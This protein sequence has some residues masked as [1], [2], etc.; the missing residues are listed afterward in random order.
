M[1]LA[2]QIVEAEIGSKKDLEQLLNGALPVDPLLGR[3][4]LGAKN[5]R[6]LA[7]Y[8]TNTTKLFC[9][10]KTDSDEGNNAQWALDTRETLQAWQKLYEIKPNFSE[11]ELNVLETTYFPTRRQAVSFFLKF[12]KSQE[13]VRNNLGIEKIELPPV[14]ERLEIL[15]QTLATYG[16]YPKKVAAREN[17]PLLCFA[18]GESRAKTPEEAIQA[19][20]GAAARCYL[21]VAGANAA[22]RQDG[23]WQIDFVANNLYENNIDID[24]FV[25]T[26]FINEVPGYGEQQRLKKFKDALRKHGIPAYRF[27]IQAFSSPDEPDK[28]FTEIR[29][30]WDNQVTNYSI[31]KS[32]EIGEAA[33]KES[34]YEVSTLGTYGHGWGRHLAILVKTLGVMNS[35]PAQDI[36]FESD[37]EAFAEIAAARQGTLGDEL[38]L[39]RLVNH[40]KT[41]GIECKRASMEQRSNVFL[42]ELRYF[43]VEYRL[44]VKSN[45][46]PLEDSL[47]RTTLHEVVYAFLN[48]DQEISGG[49]EQPYNSIKVEGGHYKWSGFTITIESISLRKP[50]GNPDERMDRRELQLEGD[51]EMYADMAIQ[52]IPGL[53]TRMWMKDVKS[54]LA[55][56]GITVRSMSAV[57]WDEKLRVTVH[58]N[59]YDSSL[60]PGYKVFTDTEVM[61]AWYDS[62][63][64]SGN[65]VVSDSFQQT[66]I[67]S[68]GGGPQNRP[69]V[70]SIKGLVGALEPVHI[71]PQGFHISEAVISL[72]DLDLGHREIA[73]TLA[74]DIERFTRR[75]FAVNPV[76]VLWVKVSP[77][78][79]SYPEGTALY[80]IRAVCFGSGDARLGLHKALEPFHS[81]VQNLPP[82]QGSGIAKL[83]KGKGLSIVCDMFAYIKLD[84][85]VRGR[86]TIPGP[87]YERFRDMAGDMDECISEALDPE[88]E[89]WVR[90]VIEQTPGYKDLARLKSALKLIEEMGYR[91]TGASQDYTGARY[92]DREHRETNVVKAVCAFKKTSREGS[93]DVKRI[94]DTLEAY[95]EIL[96]S[97]W[98][99][100]T[101]DGINRVITWNWR[102]HDAP[103]KIVPISLRYGDWNEYLSSG[104]HLSEFDTFLVEQSNEPGGL[105]ID[106][107]DLYA[108]ASDDFD[109]LWRERLRLRAMADDLKAKGWHGNLHLQAKTANIV[110]PTLWFSLWREDGYRLDQQRPDNELGQIYSDDEYL[111]KTSIQNLNHKYHFTSPGSMWAHLH[112]LRNRITDKRPGHNEEGEVYAWQVSFPYIYTSEINR[113][114][115]DA[116]PTHNAQIHAHIDED[117]KFSP[118]QLGGF[119]K[120]ALKHKTL[121]VSMAWSEF[122]NCFKNNFP[123]TH[124]VAVYMQEKRSGGLSFFNFYL[125]FKGNDFLSRASQGGPGLDHI[126]DLFYAAVSKHLKPFSPRQKTGDKWPDVYVYNSRVGEDSYLK[127]DVTFS[128]NKLS[129]PEK[130]LTVDLSESYEWTPSE[131]DNLVKGTLDTTDPAWRW[132]DGLNR[133]S[134][135]LANRHGDWIAKGTIQLTSG[136]MAKIDGYAEKKPLAYIQI[137]LVFKPGEI[138]DTDYVKQIVKQGLELIGCTVLDMATGISGQECHTTALC[139]VG[140]G[141]SSAKFPRI[142]VE[143]K[144]ETEQPVNEGEDLENFVAVALPDLDDRRRLEAFVANLKNDP[145]VAAGRVTVK[146]APNEVLRSKVPGRSYGVNMVINLIAKD[147]TMNITQAENLVKMLGSRIAKLLTN[148]GFGPHE[149]DFWRPEGGVNGTVLHFWQGQLGWQF[150][151]SQSA[152][153]S[154]A[155]AANIAF[156]NVQD[157]AGLLLQADTSAPY[158][159]MHN[160]GKI[161]SRLKEDGWMGIVKCRGWQGS[162]SQH[163]LTL[164][165]ARP[166]DTHESQDC[167]AALKSLDKALHGLQTTPSDGIQVNYE[168]RKI[169][170]YQ[171]EH[172]SFWH[173][174]A[175]ALV[176]MQGRYPSGCLGTKEAKEAKEG[177]HSI[178]S[179]SGGNHSGDVVVVADIQT[180]AQ[181]PV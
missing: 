34:G 42:K 10:L 74:R 173:W 118:Q 150:F 99:Y 33:L 20:N 11:S 72:D 17:N 165:I 6:D 109:P 110:S 159:L 92:D 85:P 163:E 12:D 26:T 139:L 90:N 40:L 56:K 179:R 78:N 15:G 84:E 148:K 32:N 59:A 114:G 37:L 125:S 112:D 172:A 51:A 166:K 103:D 70:Y 157:S 97:E 95:W 29:A 60:E 102:S 113:S 146:P 77:A 2:E 58:I 123:N 140:D 96:A 171:N 93:F 129:V 31:R 66:R 101:T 69:T 24:K 141:F 83:S 107:A 134:K 124:G 23:L 149:Y 45:R 115:L 119:V 53:R 128:I 161:T 137:Y 68:A 35:G 91:I 13:F 130:V 174:K 162:G 167:A 155:F 62:V 87:S 89:L 65:H 7:V 138:R 80:R 57:Q 27:T 9:Q 61:Q 164:K 120:T 55:A 41:L 63:K 160:L 111:V 100:D 16:F 121:A 43:I 76:Y 169:E 180:G 30:Y 127:V 5:S 18:I 88:D 116:M 98:V 152:V 142:S 153:S 4:N 49:D 47:A 48:A 71:L 158:R 46:L 131:I 67:S 8:D 54:R 94:V 156:G 168:N 144:P 39:K 108:Q 126:V 176:D 135:W 106:P 133:V 21:D 75:A 105:N 36:T 1:V 104:L 175:K 117:L 178:N 64:A 25:Q 79:N 170:G 136:Y 3:F 14:E 81:Q 132:V 22:M 154:K 52:G 145:A 86:H 147:Q 143:I 19:L 82:E 44:R 151:V 177:A 181:I 38:R 50:S 122:L 73:Y 28:K